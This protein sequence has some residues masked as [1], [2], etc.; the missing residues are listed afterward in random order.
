MTAGKILVAPLDWGMGHA[1]RMVPVIDALCTR[2]YDV[3]L[4]ANGSAA[5]F[6][7][8]R[9]PNL[10]LLSP[11][12]YDIR[13]ADKRMFYQLVKQIPETL[14]VVKQEH[15]W[16]E[17]Q[18][19][20]HQFKA[21]ISDNRFGM[22]SSKVPSVFVTHQL[23]ILS[24]VFKGVATGINKQFI[25]KFTT[26]WVPDGANNELAGELSR[27]ELTV[28][29]HYMGPL[30]RF[31]GLAG[32]GNEKTCDV[33]AVVSGPEPTRTTFEKQ[34]VEQLSKSHLKWKLLRGKPGDDTPETDQML[35]HANDAAFAELVK[36]AKL[37]VCRSGYSTL[38][39][40]IHFNTPLLCV[41]TPG[42]PEQEYLAQ[43]WQKQGWCITQNQKDMDIQK[44]IAQLSHSTINFPNIPSGLEK[45]LDQLLASL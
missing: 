25:G 28:P 24:P 36:G 40:L 5:S 23:S 8:N 30:S 20:E 37:V 4:A 22:W 16:L 2:G 32:E 42:Q 9:Y 31:T 38:M 17:K 19:E 14:K 11:P 41:P 27:G 21:V 43:H 13:Y 7:K 35:N 26:C 10:P 18:V 45:Q 44:A 3:W 29:L 1:T 39:D 34:L 15:Q 6:L 12:A 33:L